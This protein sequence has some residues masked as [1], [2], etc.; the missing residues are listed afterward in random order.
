MAPPP[1]QKEK[2]THDETYSQPLK[3]VFLRGD[4]SSNAGAVCSRIRRR[5]GAGSNQGCVPN[6]NSGDVSVIDAAT[7]TVVGTK[8]TS[9]FW[10]SFVLFVPLCG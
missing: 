7:N 10:I 5:R 1:T 2:N 4:S 6:L 9:S 3:A 8:S